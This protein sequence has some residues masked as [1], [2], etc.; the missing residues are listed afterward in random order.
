MRPEIIDKLCCPAD[1]NG[2]HLKVF[3]QNESREVM[4]GLLTCPVCNRYYPVIYGIPILTPDD[5]RVKELEDPV[6]RK[7]GLKPAGHGFVIPQL[8]E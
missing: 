3:L 6:L 5:Y 4:E 2:L 1:K 8:T 7:W